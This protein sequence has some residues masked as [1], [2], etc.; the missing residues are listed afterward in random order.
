[1]KI[2]LTYNIFIGIEE[3]GMSNQ[4]DYL[5]T[6][7]QQYLNIIILALRLTPFINGVYEFNY[8]H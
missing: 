3:T 8:S 7:Y 6:I 1:M 5:N 2:L 4:Q